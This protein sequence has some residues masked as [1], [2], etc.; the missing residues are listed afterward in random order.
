MEVLALGDNC[1]DVYVEQGIGYPGGG[2]VNTAVYLARAG[3]DVAYAGAVGDD[4][5]GRHL[6]R[7]LAEEGVDTSW[8][9][10]LS[11]LTNLAFVRH[12]D[13]DRTF[14]GTR[15]GV[16]SQ[17]R[18]QQIPVSVCVG[19]RV[20]H[21]TVDG[22]VNDLLR[23]L[24]RGKVLVT[25]DFS[26]KFTPEHQDLLPFVH[27]V[28]AS[29]AHLTESEAIELAQGWLGR[30]SR[31]VVLTRGEHGGLAVTGEGVFNCGI[32]DVPVVDTLGAGDAFI[33][34]YIHGLLHDEPAHLC[35]ERGRDLAAEALQGFGAYGHGVSL[36]ALGLA[37]EVLSWKQ[38]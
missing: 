18:W 15:R 30:G 16:R 29:A 31:I 19:A 22:G 2:S 1:I 5:S 3:L 27:V 34:G 21:T 28:F 8:V 7:S 14:L 35:L 38:A 33:A 17:F 25:Y 32:L 36:E 24:P 20:I 23:L 6:I 10:V 37:R 4:P 11:G 13:G 26:R 9:Q 12:V